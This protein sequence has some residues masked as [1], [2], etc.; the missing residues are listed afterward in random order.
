MHRLIRHQ[1]NAFKS[2]MSA[3]LEILV[4]GNALY[5]ENVSHFYIF[6]IPLLSL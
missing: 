6:Q 4:T 2:M 3:R 1:S 5:L